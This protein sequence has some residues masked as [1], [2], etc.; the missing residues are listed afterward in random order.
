MRTE[1]SSRNGYNLNTLNGHFGCWKLARA[2]IGLRLVLLRDSEETSL[3]EAWGLGRR[4]CLEQL[5]SE[6]KFEKANPVSGVVVHR[7]K[8]HQL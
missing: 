4:H 3:I 7:R 8:M 6:E 2:Q 5:G 1:L